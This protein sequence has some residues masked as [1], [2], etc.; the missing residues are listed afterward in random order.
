[1]GGLDLDDF[2]DHPTPPSATASR[3]AA[4]LALEEILASLR[5]LR[6]GSVNII[7]QDGVIIQ[8]DRTEKRRLKARNQPG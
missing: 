2:R 5:G 3:R 6:F 4:D 1:M 8:I 7:V